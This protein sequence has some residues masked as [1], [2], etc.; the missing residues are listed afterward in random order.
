MILLEPSRELKSWQK[1]LAKI[2]PEIQTR[3]I[4]RNPVPEMGLTATGERGIC[5]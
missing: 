2:S 5:K 3:Q 1:P 4:Q